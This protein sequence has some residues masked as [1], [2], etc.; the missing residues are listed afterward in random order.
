MVQANYMFQHLSPQQKDQIFQ[1]MALRQVKS[2]ETI[3]KEGDHGDMMYIV[4]HGQFNVSKKDE[5]GVNQAVITYTTSGVAFGELALMYRQKR[6]ATV[7]AATD[8]AL[9]TLGRLAFRAVLMK[10]RNIKQ[11]LLKLLKSVPVLSALRYLQLL[12]VYCDV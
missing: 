12:L 7:R 5:N 2:G 8:G 6:A 9:W 11:G 3:I 1:I 4:D 10:R